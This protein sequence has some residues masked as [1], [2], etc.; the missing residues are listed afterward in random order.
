MVRLSSVTG[1]LLLSLVATS[2]CGGQQPQE[3]VRPK[4]PRATPP[5]PFR[6]AIEKI[7][8]KAILEYA[9]RLDFDSARTVGDQQRLMIGKCPDSCRYGPLVEVH[10]EIGAAALD[11]KGLEQGRI[12][13]RFVNRSSEPYEKLA[14]PPNQES[15][16][17]VDYLGGT[18]RA[19]V[20]PSDE[21]LPITRRTAR[22]DEYHK[23]TRWAQSAARW[24]WHE[25]DETAWFTCTVAGCCKIDP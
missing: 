8:R 13:G 19:Y 1:V 20:I 5:P 17:W 15:Y 3:P 10:A 21:R 18:W 7:P 23:D 4:P 9:R 11:V 2:G 16:V 24:K 22:V 6:D 14:I 12:V 25:D